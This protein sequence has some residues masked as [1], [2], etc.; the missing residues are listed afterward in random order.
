MTADYYKVLFQDNETLGVGYTVEQ[1]DLFFLPDSGRVENWQPINLVLRDGGFPDYLASNLGC[2]LCSE[3]LKRIL[4]DGA[5]PAD[6]L[7]WL[8]VRVR[9]DTEQRPYYILHFPNPPDVLDKSRTIFAGDFV[10]KAVLSIEKTKDHRVF[11]YPGCGC[12]PLFV[13]GDVNRAIQKHVC[14][15]LEISRAPVN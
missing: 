11:A 6:E 10:V 15:G 8:E 3:V 4:D 12:L 5:A 7:Q 2:R 9:K 1:R 14:T 13:A